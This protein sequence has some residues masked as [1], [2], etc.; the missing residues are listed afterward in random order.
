MIIYIIIKI[1][2]SYFLIIKK[3][4]IEDSKKLDIFVDILTVCIF[5]YLVKRSE[6]ELEKTLWILWLGSMMI[7]MFL[8]FKL[9]DKVLKKKEEIIG[10][11]EKKEKVKKFLLK[12]EVNKVIYYGI[13][14]L[15]WNIGYWV[16]F[17]IMENGW[18]LRVWYSSNRDV[19]F[20]RYFKWDSRDFFY[21]IHFNIY[22]NRFIIY[23]REEIT[24]R[25]YIGLFRMMIIVYVIRGRMQEMSIGKYIWIRA[26]IYM[27]LCIFY[28]YFAVYLHVINYYLLWIIIIIEIIVILYIKE[29]VEYYEEKMKIEK[30][31]YLMLM[32]KGIMTREM[33]EIKD[34]FL[35]PLEIDTRM[36]WEINVYIWDRTLSNSITLNIL[37]NYMIWVNKNTKG[38]YDKSMNIRSRIHRK[39]LIEEKS[40]I[41]DILPRTRYVIVALKYF[42]YKISVCNVAAS[43]INIDIEYVLINLHRNK[44]LYLGYYEKT[45]SKTSLLMFLWMLRINKQFWPSWEGLPYNENKELK[46]FYSHIG[47]D[48]G[49]IY[50]LITLYYF[51]E[52]KRYCDENVL[53]EYLLSRW[54][55]YY[56]DA[57]YMHYNKERIYEKRKEIEIP[58][59][60]SGIKEYKMMF[61]I[62]GRIQLYEEES[63]VWNEKLQELLKE[64]E[65]KEKEE[66]KKKT[67]ENFEEY[68]YFRIL[69][70]K[71][72]IDL[73]ISDE[74]Y[75]N[76]KV[77]KDMKEFYRKT[78]PELEEIIEHIKKNNFLK[79][80]TMEI[81][82]KETRLD[83]INE[84]ERL[85]NIWHIL[86]MQ[87]EGSTVYYIE[88]PDDIY[89]YYSKTE[90]LLKEYNIKFYL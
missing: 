8:V 64:K 7:G 50:K 71:F 18:Y 89:K 9:L 66:L 83:D 51:L 88:D 77:L 19:F 25:L 75:E 3:K 4:W 38:Y 36:K 5:I 40:I 29:I 60:F 37:Y 74:G 82:V 90:N 76:G 53:F 45:Y 62:M 22:T 47:Y 21:N 73:G 33:I 85:F 54:I 59:E 80:K 43:G 58:E 67:I 78:E 44:F 46:K 39:K 11:I 52:D 86:I 70:G 32:E 35:D 2:L 87:Y 69:S 57:D 84:E 49:Y 12:P 16:Y 68:R 55:Y 81:K 10:W 79:L 17:W 1:L 24:D 6:I 41:W 56:A 13:W 31:H 65:E 61:R 15:P 72:P 42:G 26:V 20:W 30:M 23:I 48:G 14:M 28:L 34:K 63:M 27:Y